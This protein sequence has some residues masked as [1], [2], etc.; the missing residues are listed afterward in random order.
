MTAIVASAVLAWAISQISKVGYGVLRHGASDLSRMTWRLIWAGGMPSSHCAFV[1][2][3]VV[4]VGA[5]EGWGSNLFGLALIVFAVVV[6][7][8]GKLHHIYCVLQDKF[9][10]FK[11]QVCDDPMLRD[12]VG[13][14]TAEIVAGVIIGLI[15]SAAVIRMGLAR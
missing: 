3:A 9:P 2:A 4:V 6:Y 8:R 11:E 7:D 12:L 14:T 1:T 10:P 13:H 15:S 5:R